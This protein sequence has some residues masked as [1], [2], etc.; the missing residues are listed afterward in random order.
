MVKMKFRKRISS[1]VPTSISGLG[2]DELG[3]KTFLGVDPSI[4]LSIIKLNQLE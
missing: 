2:G 1:S 4:S 3:L